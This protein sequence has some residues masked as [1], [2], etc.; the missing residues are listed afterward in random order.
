[1][2]H[3]RTP[4]DMAW[5][6]VVRYGPN[7]SSILELF[8][9]TDPMEKRR[10]SLLHLIVLGLTEVPRDLRLEL[11]QSTS[12]INTTN[13]HGRTALSWAAGR[14]GVNAVDTLL[15][16]GADPE[17]DDKSGYTATH[18][19]ASGA[20]ESKAC[21]HSLLR[22]GANLNR[23][24]NWGSTPLHHAVNRQSIELL[25]QYGADINAKNAYGLTPVFL[26]CQGNNLV[27]A[28]ALIESGADIE[29]RTVF[30]NTPLLQAIR[31][32]AKDI[33]GLLL[34]HG[35][36]YYV[37]DHMNQTV[38]HHTAQSYQVE[39][40]LIQMLTALDWQGMDVNARDTD[41]Y[42]ARDD[43]ADKRETLSSELLVAYEALFSKVEADNR[44]E[45][46]V[47][48]ITDS[49]DEDSQEEDSQNEDSSVFMDAI[50][51]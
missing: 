48:D 1:M 43:F 13:V 32:G 23:K 36:I 50:E 18:F 51:Y 8:S 26:T 19:A 11:Q 21:L 33:V 5:D 47:S 44:E 28:L 29:A 9:H 35:A 14:G 46:R 16:F 42:T 34:S 7:D 6:K 24:S 27:C 25:M 4:L 22:G 12:I 49:Q 17:I 2:C 15:A 45:P 10:F 41:G 40:G 30:G 3:T 37:R 39:T 38:L 20:Y 31:C